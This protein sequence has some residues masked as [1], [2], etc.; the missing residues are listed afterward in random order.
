MQAQNLQTSALIWNENHWNGNCIVKS[1]S[2]KL[3]LVTV[4]MVKLA[5]YLLNTHLKGLGMCRSLR[6]VDMPVLQSFL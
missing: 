3:L 1:D 4:S 2:A 6:T 5:K